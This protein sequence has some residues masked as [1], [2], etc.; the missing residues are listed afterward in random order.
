MIRRTRSER[1]STVIRTG[2]DAL[3]PTAAAR[4]PSIGIG[5]AA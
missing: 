3:L 4:A 1:Q 2:A 5:T